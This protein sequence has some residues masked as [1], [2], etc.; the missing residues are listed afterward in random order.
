MWFIVPLSTSAFKEIIP[1]RLIWINFGHVL[2]FSLF[3]ITR[4]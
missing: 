3:F 4:S 1:K 2:I